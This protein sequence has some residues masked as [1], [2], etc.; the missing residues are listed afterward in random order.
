MFEAVP[1]SKQRREKRAVGGLGGGRERCE[2]ASDGLGAYVVYAVPHQLAFDQL[3]EVGMA[4]AKRGQPS[5]QAAIRL[6]V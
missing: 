4:P 2:P 5:E 3:G 1:L 6:S